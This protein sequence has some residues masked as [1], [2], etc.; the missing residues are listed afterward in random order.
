MAMETVY[1]L[2]SVI[3]GLYFC[4]KFNKMVKVDRMPPISTA[5]GKSFFFFSWWEIVFPTVDKRGKRSFANWL[6]HCN[7]LCAQSLC[8]SWC[9]IT[10]VP[11]HLLCVWLASPFR[12]TGLHANEKRP[13][14]WDIFNQNQALRE[15]LKCD[16]SLLIL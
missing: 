13:L 10:Q 2:T 1:K 6:L 15:I 12:G 16:D 5:T 11:F 4:V 9:H 8:L 3:V 7:R 14:L